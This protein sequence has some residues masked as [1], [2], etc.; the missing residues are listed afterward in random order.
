M[1]GAVSYHSGL[2]AE[3]QVAE[4][5]RRS[6]RPIIAS[7]W[8]GTA[9]EI[10]LI[11]REGAGL[12]FIEVKRAETFERAAESLSPRQA[13]RIFAAASEFLAGALA[14]QDSEVRFDVALVDAA[15]A[16]RIVENAIG[17]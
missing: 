14:G 2:A 13:A 11:A 6:G 4:S 5:Y 8:R 10:D 9:G 15:G 17:F 16:I 12:V 1:S 3:H 7:R